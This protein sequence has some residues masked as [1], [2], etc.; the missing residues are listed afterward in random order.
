MGHSEYAPVTRERRAWN[1][2]RK[3]GAKRALGP[4]AFGL[5]ESDGYAIAR[6]LTSQSTA[7]CVDAMSSRSRSVTLSVAAR[8]APSAIVTRQKTGRPV[9]FE[10]LEPAAVFLPGFEIRGGVPDEF[11]FPSR[12]DQDGAALCTNR[13][14]NSLAKFYSRAYLGGYAVKM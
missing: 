4:Y 9:Q 5:I 11:V 3:L 13:A 7:S 2:G 6:C 10:L 14:G 12:I 8:F 1:A